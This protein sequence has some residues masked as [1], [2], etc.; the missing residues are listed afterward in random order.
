MVAEVLGYN[1]HGRILYKFQC[2][3]GIQKIS[4]NSTSCNSCGCLRREAMLR[5]RQGWPILPKGEASKNLLYANYKRS[6]KARHI[7][8][9][10][11]REEFIVKTCQNC[12]Y[13]GAIPN[14]TTRRLSQSTHYNGNY[15]YN[16]LDRQNNT[17][18]YTLE[19]TVPCCK[20]CNRA[21]STLSVKD[22]IAWARLVATKSYSR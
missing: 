22:F 3:C 19:N 16:G 1:R 18:G 8:F 2:D 9:S 4:V 6:A 21:K 7:E 20:I 14:Q 17:Q 13:C 15:V 11:T 12:A 5:V 10:L